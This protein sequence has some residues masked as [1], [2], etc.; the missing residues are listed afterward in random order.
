MSCVQRIYRS[1]VAAI[2]SRTLP[3]KWLIVSLALFVAIFACSETNAQA[4]TPTPAVKASAI[5]D[6]EFGVFTGDSDLTAED[7]ICVFNNQSSDFAVSFLT[8]SGSFVITNA[9]NSVPFTVRFKVVNGSYTAVSYN[10]PASFSGAHTSS[11][12]CNSSSNAMYEI[13]MT[14]ADLLSV[15]PGNY[16]A[17]LYIVIEQAV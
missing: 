7:E 5:D 12:T 11:M 14:K 3:I 15:R 2:L 13:K 1:E 6:V 9:A 10:T 8:S 16:S 17:T 4:P